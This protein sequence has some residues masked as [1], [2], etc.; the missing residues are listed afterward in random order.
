MSRKLLI[1]FVF[2]LITVAL[3]VLFPTFP[4]RN[5]GRLGILLKTFNGSR[6]LAWTNP[7]YDAL[8][9]NRTKPNDQLLNYNTTPLLITTSTNLLTTLDP[10]ESL[11]ERS[12]FP[13]RPYRKTDNS[14][15]V[16]FLFQTRHHILASL[17]MHLIRKF[18]KNLVAIELFTDGTASQEMIE[19]ATRHQAILNSFP[20]K[21]H[22]PNAGPSDRNTDVV[23]WAISTKAKGYL[24]HGHAIIMLDG[25]VLPVSPYDSGT[26]LNGHDVICR[27]HPAL[28]ARYCWVGLIC[29]GPGLH[30]SIGSFDVS[31]DMRSGK[32]YDSGGKTAEFFLKHANTSFAYMRE[33]ILYHTDRTLFWG[34]FDEDIE[35]IGKN[36]FRCDK[37]GPEIFFSPF[38]DSKAV[39]YHMISA[40]S[41]WRF[42]HQD[43]RRKSIHDSVMRSPLGATQQHDE[44]TMATSIEKIQRMPLIPFWGNLTCESVCRN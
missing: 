20:E 39:F 2:S 41:E 8:M 26:L 15:I 19:V 31:Q 7:S 38:N 29:I 18:S 23:N 10:A 5:G 3:Y 1:L 36:F 35:W 12:P 14:T 4:F 27:K 9:S 44:A 33:T 32:A 6:I 34:A 11:V 37:C 43:G 21:N 40:T 25:D 17:Q 42:G 13:L 24:A 28:F 22:Q 30:D 16:A